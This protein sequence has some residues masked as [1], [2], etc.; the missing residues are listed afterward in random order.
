LEGLAIENVDTFYDRLEYFTAI[1]YNLWPFCIHSLWSFAIYF[2]HFGMFGPRKIWQ[3]WPAFRS[4]GAEFMSDY[5][6][7]LSTSFPRANKQEIE[8]IV[9]YSE[10]NQWFQWYPF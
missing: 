4:E 3:P 8:K 2:S 6:T 9:N 1:W 10:E 7:Q 5:W